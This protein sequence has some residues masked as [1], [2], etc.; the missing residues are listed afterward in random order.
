MGKKEKIYCAKRKKRKEKKF[1]FNSQHTYK[2][3]KHLNPAE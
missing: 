3:K 1:E 2:L